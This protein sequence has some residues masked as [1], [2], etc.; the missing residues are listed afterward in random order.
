MSMGV[1]KRQQKRVSQASLM[2]VFYTPKL[3]EGKFWNF[4]MTEFSEVR[5]ESWALSG[6][7]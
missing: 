4:A 1:Y 5:K 2:V 6:F 7:W 3:V